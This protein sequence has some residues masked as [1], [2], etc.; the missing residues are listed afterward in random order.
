MEDGVSKKRRVAR[1]C[2]ACKRRKV[3][4]NGGMRCQQCDHFNLPCVYS[5]D[6]SLRRS[7]A[8]AAQR[9]AVIAECKQTDVNQGLP[10]SPI[11]LAPKGASLPSPPLTAVSSIAFNPTAS[12]FLDM[13]PDYLAYV[14]PVNPVIPE[15]EIR[16][17][18]EQMHTDRDAGSFIYAF[19]ATTINLTQPDSLPGIRDQITRLIEKSLELRDPMGLD[20]QP[21]VLKIMRN[22]FLQICLMGLRKLDLGFFYLREAIT[23]VHM[24]RIENA[25]AMAEL[26]PMERARRQRLY[27]EC[28]IHERF[29]ALS[30]YKPTCLKPL[31][32]LPDRDH[33]LAPSTEQGWNHIIETF[34]LV[35]QEFIDLW[36]GDRAQVTAEW[37]ERKHRELEDSKWQMEVSYLSA[38]QQA[39]LIVT[40]QWLRTLTW[41]MAMSNTLLS[42]LAHSESLSLTLPLRLSSQL[43]G[44]ITRVSREAIGIHGSGIL[45]KLF[46]ITDTIADVVLHLPPQASLTSDTLSRVEDML[47]LKRFMF[48][49]PRIQPMHKRILMDK[50]RLIKEIYPHMEEIDNLVASPAS[51][52]SGKTFSEAGDS[53]AASVQDIFR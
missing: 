50:F 11:P 46:E 40:R 14:Y 26:D 37:I 4:C 16:T 33:S 25:E 31:L 8:K 10:R 3:R 48:S 49:F 42:S 38:L 41:Q 39:D 6:S 43:R 21:T 23:M 9:G 34:L 32:G 5:A 44:F 36:L 47:F 27:W 30:N 15:A 53:P 28:F 2:D 17:C 45:D 18:V 51:I 19:A 12:Y 24:L 1:A 13:I 7:R 29:T 52:R 22:I 20:S 35:D